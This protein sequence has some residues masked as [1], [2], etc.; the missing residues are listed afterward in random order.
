M[1]NRS[2]ASFGVGVNRSA[3]HGSNGGAA[4]LS[5]EPQ[6][7]RRT[8]ER[9]WARAFHTAPV[10]CILLPEVIPMS[11]PARKQEPPI[12]TLSL[13]ERIHRRAYELYVQRG[14]QSGS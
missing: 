2:I 1:I 14:N 4:T 7:T 12:E 13:E 10:G 3:K 6:S 11:A 5:A 8:A 9:N